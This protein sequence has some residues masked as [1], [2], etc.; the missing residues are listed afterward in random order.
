[1]P[2]L[3]RPVRQSPREENTAMRVTV[4]ATRRRDSRRTR[5]DARRFVPGFATAV[6]QTRQVTPRPSVEFTLRAGSVT[7]VVH[8]TPEVGADII[9]RRIDI[10][11]KPR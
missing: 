8:L 6:A 5:G 9:A 4:P 1:M 3:G 7:D 2:S 11:A 10:T